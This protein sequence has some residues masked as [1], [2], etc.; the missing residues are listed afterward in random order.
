MNKTI[1]FLCWIAVIVIL[2]AQTTSAATRGIRRVVVQDSSGKTIR[3]YNQSHALVIGV[4]DYQDTG[5]PDLESVK[6][7][8][9]SV[10]ETLEMHG[11]NV[12]VSLNPNTREF[13]DVVENFI[14]E[15]GY[16]EENRLL[17]Y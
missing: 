5:W 6:E 9:R 15:Y 1:K 11:F 13:I 12:G 17:F 16:E 10:R 2:S 4:S 3:L 14:R 7:D 8:V